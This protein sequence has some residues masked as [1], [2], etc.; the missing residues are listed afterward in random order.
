M[1]KHGKKYRAAAEKIDQQKDYEPREA[2]LMPQWSFIS[3]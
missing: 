3:A 1:A 2:I